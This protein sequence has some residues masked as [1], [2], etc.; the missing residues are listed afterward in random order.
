MKRNTFTS[1]RLAALFTFVLSTCGSQPPATA[2][3]VEE[4]TVGA[5][6][7]SE[8]IVAA[9]PVADGAIDP[10]AL[11]TQEEAEQALGVATGTGQPDNSPPLYSCSYETS[12]YDLVQVILVV[13]DDNAQAQ[14][15]FQTAININGYPE[16]SGLG[17][18]AYNAQ[19]ILDIDVLS[20]RYEI[21]IDIS[22]SSDDATQLQKAIDLA[23]VGLTRLP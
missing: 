11:I 17:D 13:Y 14:D 23:E 16:L 3:V 15:A 8:T 5:P 4:A 21:S 10:C 1:I 18:R 2:V 6:L 20:G 19:P 9:V 22:D 7:P 12:T